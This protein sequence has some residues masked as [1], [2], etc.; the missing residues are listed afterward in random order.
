MKILCPT[1]FSGASL[2]A[3]QYAAILS[4]EHQGSLTLM[5]VLS[6]TEFDAAL[7]EDDPE[8]TYEAISA[9][10]EAKLN[11]LVAQ[12]SKEFPDLQCHATMRNGK[13]STELE[14]LSTQEDYNL[15]V[16][17]TTGKGHAG[18][19]FLGSYAEYAINDLLVPTLIVPEN[20]EVR[21]IKKI[22]YA[23]TMEQEDKDI[24]QEIVSLAHLFNA[25]IRVVHINKH[26]SKAEEQRYQAYQD[27][28]RTFVNYDYLFFDSEPHDSEVAWDLDLY[29]TNQQADILVTITRHRNF[30]GRLFHN[31]VNTQLAYL[32]DY[33]ILVYKI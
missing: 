10:S 16:M 1:D 11:A 33:P 21:P 7:G 9:K 3:I 19:A 31:S 29:V 27:Q 13:F 30:L 17:G 26:N 32:T 14:L 4:N 28:L 6:E 23:T 22:V 25:V 8:E 12:V 24:I 2:K 18:E 15:V 5:H 20:A